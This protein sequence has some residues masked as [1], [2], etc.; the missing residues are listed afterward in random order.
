M[1]IDDLV[2]QLN[3]VDATSSDMVIIILN[4]QFVITA[5]LGTTCRDEP[6]SFGSACSGT[7]LAQNDE[8]CIRESNMNAQYMNL[9][10]IRVTGS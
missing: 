2:V 9:T 1:L 10:I 8:P 4:D 6:A 3:N 5:G 7:K